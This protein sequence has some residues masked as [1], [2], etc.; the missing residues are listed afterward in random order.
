MGN[1]TVYLLETR[2]NLYMDWDSEGKHGF[3]PR[4]ELILVGYAPAYRLPAGK[5]KVVKE[6]VTSTQR[7]TLSPNTLGQMLESIT[8]IKAQL[9]EFQKMAE[10]MNGCIAKRPAEGEPPTTDP[11][12]LTILDQVNDPE[13]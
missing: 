4:A 13:Q 2:A 10:F 6:M 3:S 7:I 9:E 11:D 8:S 12:Q 1:S 5:G